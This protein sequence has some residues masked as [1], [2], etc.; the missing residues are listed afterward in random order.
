M[1]VRTAIETK[2][3]EAL[4]PRH[5]EVLDESGRHAVPPGSESHFRLRIVASVFEGRRLLDR[6]RLVNRLLA[7]ELEAGVHALALETLTP[8]EWTAR[9]GAAARGRAGRESPP[10][11][12]GDRE[13][14]PD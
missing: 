6:H 5:L 10:C 4:A 8:A 12:G 7:A 14:I 11:L 13:P 9:D 1:N 2:L 3:R